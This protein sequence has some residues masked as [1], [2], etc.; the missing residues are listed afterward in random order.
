MIRI[1]NITV[2]PPYQLNCKFNCG[3]I[4]KLNILPLIEHHKHLAG[5]EKMCSQIDNISDQFNLHC[6]KN[7]TLLIFN[8]YES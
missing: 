1:T 4:K 2:I 3:A 7:I 8:E 5:V 6:E